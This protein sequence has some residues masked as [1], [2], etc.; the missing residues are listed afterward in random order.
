VEDILP[1]VPYYV[2]VTAFDFGSP[3]AGLSALESD[4]LN[5]FVVEYPLLSADTVELY[6]LETY[7]YPNPYRL[8]G[9]YAA[10]GYE[11]RD[12]SQ[13][14]DRSH[15]IHF[16]NLP[17]RCTIS[18]FSLDGDLVRTWEHDYPDGGPGSMHDSW[19]LI[20]RNTQA[21]VSGIYYWVVD[22]PG[23][24]SQIGKLVIIK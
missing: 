8:D 19:D 22:E 23:G 5:N 9:D 24:R 16:A 4:P 1:T 21:V 13:P 18:I 7:V 3:G 17:R 20:S 14:P 6:D 12:G 15:R 10:A 2:A 11:N